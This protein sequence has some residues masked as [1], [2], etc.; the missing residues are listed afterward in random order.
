[1]AQRRRFHEA[2]KRHAVTTVHARD[3]LDIFSPAPRVF[4]LRA[5][6]FNIVTE[7]QTV[8]GANGKAHRQAQYV[9]MPGKPAREA[10]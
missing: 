5:L 10:A 4:E 1:M 6:G 2:L 9:L 8:T 7:W 3:V